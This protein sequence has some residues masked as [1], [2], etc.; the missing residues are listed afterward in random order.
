MR[1]SQLLKDLQEYMEFYGDQPVK[2]YDRDSND[3]LIIQSVDA[4]KNE[5]C[6]EIR[7]LDN[8]DDEEE[9]DE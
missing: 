2:V 5:F 9:E 1:V 7:N 3:T 6:I 8:Y 4:Y